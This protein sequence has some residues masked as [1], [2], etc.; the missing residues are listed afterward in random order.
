[1]ELSNKECK[2][3]IEELK[4]NFGCN[5]YNSY[6]YVDDEFGIDDKYKATVLKKYTNIIKL[7][8]NNT[9]IFDVKLTKQIIQEFKEEIIKVF[10][11]LERYA[12]LED[13]EKLDIM[14]I[15]FYSHFPSMFTKNKWK[16]YKNNVDFHPIQKYEHA[17]INLNDYGMFYQFPLYTKEIQDRYIK[18]HETKYEILKFHID[19]NPIMRY[20]KIELEETLTHIQ[21]NYLLS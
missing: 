1:M 21:A 10:E 5:F 20:I 7:F 11:M 19:N 15:S 17:K 3:L 4:E 8:S 6:E 13:V 18:E 16:K 12:K 2:I 14:M 9:L